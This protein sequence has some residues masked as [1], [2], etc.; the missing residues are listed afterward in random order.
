MG[1]DKQ[2]IIK[3]AIVQA[4]TVLYNNIDALKKLRIYANEAAKQSAKL[5][6][7]PGQL[8]SSYVL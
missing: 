7:F 5:V 8:S 1:H 3:V 4:G 2:D 6:L